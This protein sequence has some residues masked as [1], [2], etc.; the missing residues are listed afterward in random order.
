[1]PFLTR[2]EEDQSRPTFTSA[3]RDVFV[4]A[5]LP[6][7]L[8]FG[9]IV[10]FGYLLKGPLE[11]LSKSENGVSTWFEDQRTHTYNT[12]TNF[13]S[14]VGNTEYVIAVAVIVCAVVWW[15]T[16]EWWFAVVPLIAISLQATVFVL[17]AAVVG[18]ERPPVERLDPTPPTSS[19]PSGH[20][21]ASTALYVSFALM[22][23]RISNVVVRRVVIVLCII[24][25]LLVSYARLYRGAHHVSDIVVGMLNGV[26]C[27]LLAWNYLRREPASGTSSRARAGRN[28]SGVQTRA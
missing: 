10:G 18:R 14:M 26:L 25:P 1:M 5:V 12:I 23:T 22:A 3:L 8:V 19:Y 4:R 7:V 9:V 20:V 13:M 28:E 11:G 21:G 15:R 6:A 2:Y 16:K 17:A 24:A 27:A